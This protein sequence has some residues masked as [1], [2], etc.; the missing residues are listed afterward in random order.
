MSSQRYSLSAKLTH[1]VCSKR[2]LPALLS[3]M[4]GTVRPLYHQ[5]QV[6]A[7]TL[8][9]L[10]GSRREFLTPPGRTAGWLHNQRCRLR[11]PNL[12]KDLV[13][14]SSSVHTYSRSLTTDCCHRKKQSREHRGL[15]TSV[16]SLGC[17]CTSE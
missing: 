15:F 13:L 6:C 11:S 17:S 16:H 14:G 5:D 3:V 9:G 1:I 4:A 2:H 7:N 12:L 8:T 10:A